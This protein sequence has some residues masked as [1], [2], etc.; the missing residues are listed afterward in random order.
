MGTLAR[1]LITVTAWQ[2]TATSS[3]VV[4]SFTWNVF[5]AHVADCDA[6]QLLLVTA[7]C[8]IHC[9]Q[10]HLRTDATAA[11]QLR[12]RSLGSRC[13]PDFWRFADRV[14]DFQRSHLL[15]FCS[16]SSSWKHLWSGCG[17]WFSSATLCWRC[18]HRLLEMFCSRPQLLVQSWVR[19]TFSTKDGKPKIVMKGSRR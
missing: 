12:L 18:P 8:L 16:H 2:G 9:C 14:Q 10:G 11:S 1:T 17:N 13:W 7:G 4:A 19:L 3:A 5:I 6:A 15:S